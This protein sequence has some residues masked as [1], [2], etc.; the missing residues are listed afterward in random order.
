VAAIVIAA[1][2]LVGDVEVTLFFLLHMLSKIL[3]FE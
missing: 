3:L 1:N 2:K